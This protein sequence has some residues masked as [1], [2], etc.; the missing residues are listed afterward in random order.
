MMSTV[1]THVVVMGKAR[2]PPLW[3]KVVS[4]ETATSIYPKSAWRKIS[5]SGV[6]T[7]AWSKWRFISK[8]I[9]IVLNNDE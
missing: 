2:A 4:P 9:A 8:K 7:V 1:F 3:P 6:W 5:R